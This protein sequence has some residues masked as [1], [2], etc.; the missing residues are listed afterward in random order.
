MVEVIDSHCLGSLISTWQAPK[1]I[2]FSPFFLFPFSCV[3]VCMYRGIHV[4]TACTHICMH[5]E[6][7][8]SYWELSLIGLLPYLLRSQSNPELA[9]V[10]VLLSSLLWE[11]HLLPSEAGITGMLPHI[12]DIYMGLRIWTLVLRAE[13]QALWPLS[14]QLLPLFLDSGGMVFFFLPW[15][16]IM[17]GLGDRR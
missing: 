16:S 3:Y 11:P 15:W 12:S 6:T 14:C 7:G 8:S 9:D 2:I 13:R 4:W 10:I 1:S 17:S 5:V